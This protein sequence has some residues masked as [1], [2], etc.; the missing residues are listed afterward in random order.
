MYLCVLLSD[1]VLHQYLNIFWS[2]P[3]SK[4]LYANASAS[5]GVEVVCITC[6]NYSGFDQISVCIEFQAIEV[7]SNFL[8]LGVSDRGACQSWY[9]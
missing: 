3:V 1:G 8:T 4:A 2:L 5:N 7:F 6:K 9:S